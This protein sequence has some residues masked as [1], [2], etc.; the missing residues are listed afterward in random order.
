MVPCLRPDDRLHALAA[1]SLEGMKTASVSPEGVGAAQ[2]F[3]Y[4]ATSVPFRIVTD[5][6]GV[7]VEDTESDAAFIPTG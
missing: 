3:E 4:P 2:G 1:A 7:G 6:I 5:P